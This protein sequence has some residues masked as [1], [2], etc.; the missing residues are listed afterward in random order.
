MSE[1]RSSYWFAAFFPNGVA[2]GIIGTLI[3]LYLVQELKASLVDLGLMMFTA[4]ILLIPASILLGS[5]PDRYKMSKPFI[6]VSFLGVSIMLFLMSMTTSVIVFQALYVVKELFNYLKGPSTS[7]LIAESYER[8][9]RSSMIARQGFIEGLGGIVG[10]SLCIFTI[11]TLGYKTLLTLTAPFVLASFILA[12]LIIQEPPLYIERSL[13]RMDSV[14][15]QMAGLSYR[16]TD[17]GTIVSDL[18]GEWRFGKKHNMSL[19][20]LGRAFFAFATSNAT[21]TLSIFLLKGAG[22]T[23]SLVFVAFQIRSIVGTL[24]YLFV[25]RFIGGKGEGAIITGTFIRVIAIGLLPAVIWLPMPFSVLAVSLI[26]S[27]VALSWSIYSVGV[28]LIT[29]LH[30][31]PG[32]LGFYDAVTSLGGALGNYSSGLI[33]MLY[34]FETLF[35]I[36]SLLFALALFLFY[37]SMK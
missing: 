7:I 33:P 32:R 10:L 6:L 23:S 14:I 29:V 26:L 28:G 12:L 1:G 35:L 37:M 22:F 9:I 2:L 4:S 30:S 21:A 5:L 15:E 27:F 18:S 3:P 11:D 31:A 17:Q 19:F 36:S 20:A 25:D 13:D 8:N 16:L 34:G 24:S